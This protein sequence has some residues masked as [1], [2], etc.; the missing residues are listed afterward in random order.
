MDRPTTARALIE[1]VRGALQIETDVLDEA[2]RSRLKGFLKLD[3]DAQDLVARLASRTKDVFRPDRLR[4]TEQAMVAA[5]GTSGWVEPV[6]AVAAKV[7]L[8]TVKE[9]RT[10][11]EA[12]GI[13]TTG[14][15][16]AIQERINALGDSQTFTDSPAVL[17]I[18]HKKLFRRAER[19]WFFHPYRS[20]TDW[21]LDAVG[22]RR[23]PVYT[24][25]PK[26]GNGLTRAEIQEFEH[27]EAR[28]DTENPVTQLDWALN[29]LENTLNEDLSAKPFSV[30]K[31]ARR[32]A[33]DAARELERQH[34][35]DGAA[36]VY[37]ILVSENTSPSRRGEW[38][39]RLAHSL[40][41]AGKGKRAV[42]VLDQWRHRVPLGTRIALERTGQRLAKKTRTGWSPSIPLKEARQRYVSLR[43][44]PSSSARIEYET[45]E[46]IQAQTGRRVLRGESSPWTT[47]FALLMYDLYWLPVDGMLPAQGLAGPLDLGTRGFALARADALEQTLAAVREGRAVELV[48]RADSMH[49]GERLAG[50]S[51]SRVGRDEV[52]AICQA[53]PAEALAMIIERLAREG[54]SARRGLPDL[55][56]LPGTPS[57][58]PEGF[59]ARLTESLHLVEVK[60]PGDRLRDDQRAWM[61]HL[62]TVGVKCEIWQVRL[63]NSGVVGQEKSPSD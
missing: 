11:C 40:D 25:G 23:F 4:P 34:K 37:E 30:R 57:K 62:C 9:L 48:E 29:V 60:G 21:I 8:M 49:R 56:I 51:W 50:A 32:I 63:E 47:I 12:I 39:L 22:A 42:S 5:L 38:A 18:R 26:A 58:L 20:R 45:A 52:A 24:V 7:E 2:E 14:R 43:R 1:I 15:K 41:H 27:A 31:I 44:N 53:M 35:Y 28:L 61:H 54:W 19:I 59:P 6:Y 10:A 13:K 33:S 36:R 46:M 17:R 55:I 3:E 16:A